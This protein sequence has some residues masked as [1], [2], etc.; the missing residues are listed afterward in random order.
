MSASDAS[1]IALKWATRLGPLCGEDIDPCEVCLD[2]MRRV[3]LPVDPLERR[4]TH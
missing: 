3:G 4:D 1:E 2:A